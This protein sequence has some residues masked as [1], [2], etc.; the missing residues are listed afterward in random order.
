M[1]EHIKKKLQAEIALLEHELTTE[2]PRRDQEGRRP[3]RPQRKRRVPH[4]QAAPGLRQRSPRP[5]QEAHGRALAREPRPTSR[6]TRSP[7]APRSS[8]STAPRTRRS[9]T[10]SSPAKSPMSR[11]VSSPPP[12]PS[13][14]PSSASRSATSPPS[15]RPA[16]SANSKFSSSSPS[17][18]PK[19]K[20]LLQQ[21]FAFAVVSLAITAL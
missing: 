11:R 9:P 13:A 15:S 3:R 7:S 6:T 5:A 21:I 18:T 14:A 17:T 2:L 20:D 19:N 10:S 16:A 12:R 4:G 8:S 1:P